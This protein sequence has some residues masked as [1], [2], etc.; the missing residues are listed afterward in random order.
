MAELEASLQKE[1][2]SI[3]E[4]IEICYERKDF[5]KI[6]EL[7]LIKWKKLPPPKENWDESFHIAN[8]LVEAYTETQQLDEAVHWAKVL[9]GCDPE[10]LDS[11]EKEMILG[12]ALFEAEDYVPAH[13]KFK[14]AYSKSKGRQ[15]TEEDPKYLD[16]Y[17]HPEKYIEK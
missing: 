16:F 6:I 11:G 5:K 10:R 4:Q 17:K 2:D 1:F 12:K 3:D 15:F 7:Q 8:S 13:E 14:V 9:Q